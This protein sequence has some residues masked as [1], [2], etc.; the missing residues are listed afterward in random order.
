MHPARLELTIALARSLGLLDQVELVAPDPADEA[1]LLRAH[2]EDYLEAVRIAHPATLPEVPGYGL[3]GDDNPVFENMHE[4]AAVIVAG[5]VR[6]AKA[7]AGGEAD[8]AVSIG[9]GMHHAMPGSASG[10]CLYNDVVVAISWLLDQHDYR[11]IAYIDVDVHHGDGVQRAFADDPRVLTVSIHQDPATLWPGTGYS[12]EV[13]VGSAAGSVVNLPLPAGTGDAEW[14]RAYHAVVPQVVTAFEPDIIVSQCGVD[15]H[16]ADPLGGF[17]LTVDG[18]RAAFLAMR[19]LA[20][21]CARGRWLALGGGGYDLVGT[22]PRAWTHL[23]ATATGAGVDVST[24]IPQ[25]WRTYAEEITMESDLP[26]TMGDGGDTD[27]L[28]WPRQPESGGA[29]DLLRR[30]DAAIAD[31]RRAVFPLHGLDPDIDSPSTGAP[32]TGADV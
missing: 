19:E 8:R 23:L 1:H 11:R 14:L 29:T 32:T 28:P 4:A 5:S 3:G 2:T 7:I 20:D 26:H 15:T 31:T 10:F 21:T 24:P 6:A 18:Q 13:G 30:V 27:Y 25:S 9:G 17:E 12:S 22:V 16:R